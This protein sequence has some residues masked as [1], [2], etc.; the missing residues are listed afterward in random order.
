MDENLRT[1]IFRNGEPIP[2]VNDKTEWE[3]TNTPAY[4][5]PNNIFIVD[6][7][8]TFGRLY[9]WFAAYSTNN[10]APKG[11]HV[12]TLDDWT[13][14]ITYLGGIDIAGGKLKE[15]GI[16][17]WHTPNECANNE[18][19]FTALPGVIRVLDWGFINAYTHLQS[20]W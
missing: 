6:S 11:W 3:N 1:T 12:P 20:S 15:T 18:S 17:H 4:C 7:I 9:N 16:S 5:N 10:I 13:T 8:T 2:E 14:L 19:G